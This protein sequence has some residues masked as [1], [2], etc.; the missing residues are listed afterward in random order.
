MDSSHITCIKEHLDEHG[1]VIIPNVLSQEE[2][3]TAI[4]YFKEFQSGIENHDII[5]NKIDPHG[6]Y[7]Y[8]NVGHNKSAWYIR[9]RESVINV[10]QEIWNTKDLVVSFD[11]SC[12][13]SKNCKKKDN[14]WTHT[15]QAPA[16]K[17]HSCYQ[18][19][20]SLTD[21]KERT[22]VVYDKSH[23][24]HE[25][26]FIDRNNNSTNNWQLIDH[27]YLSE[28]MDSKLKLDVSAGSLVIWDS[29]TFHQNQYGAPN[30]EERMV[31]YVCY[32]PKNNKLNSIAMRA[33][34]LKYLEDRR[35]TSHWCYPI[36]VNSLQP[37]T[38]GDDNIKINYS[39][40]QKSNLEDLMEQILQLI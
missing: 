24:L 2:I 4:T 33:K 34:R 30:S 15:D 13:I 14:I 17:G 22:L 1:W 31:Q 20:V 35:T 16:T 29:R 28:I 12:Y 37:R 38:Y 23:L 18:G 21:N 40:L 19:F 11:G 32:M 8:Y 6:I 5:H 25:K 36:R 7:K 3:D 27:D 9:T 10:Y 26:Y 39:N